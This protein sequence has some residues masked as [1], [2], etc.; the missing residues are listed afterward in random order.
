V[1]LAAGLI[2]VAVAVATTVYLLTT[3]PRVEGWRELAARHGEANGLDPALVLAVIRVESK[4]RAD[5]VSRAGARGL[6]QLMPRTA[7][8]VAQKSGV[9][10]R[11]PDQLFD[12]E[13]NIRLGTRYLAELR[14]LFDDDPYLYLAAYNAGM[15]R[16]D[17]WRLQ[18]PQLSSRELV[19]RFAPSETKAYVPRVLAAW[20][21]WKEQLRAEER[22]QD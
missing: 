6:M 13:L 11:S 8:E 16:V 21:A 14:R 20:E 1:L 17:R 7:E 19:E 12:P 3:A 2:V 10:L 9:E 18:N 5:A 4:G 15:G 22:E